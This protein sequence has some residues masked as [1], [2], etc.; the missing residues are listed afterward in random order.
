[1]T[2]RSPVPIEN[3]YD[4]SSI[5]TDIEKKEAFSNLFSFHVPQFGTNIHASIL[6]KKHEY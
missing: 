4:A 5:H 2:E 6:L 3:V 1:M